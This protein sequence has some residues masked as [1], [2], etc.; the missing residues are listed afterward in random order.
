MIWLK[1]DGPEQWKW[2]VEKMYGEI[3]IQKTKNGPFTCIEKD[4][5]LIDYEI[6]HF[7]L[8]R[9]SISKP[10]DC[11]SFESRTA[12]FGISSILIFFGRLV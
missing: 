2:K 1:M 3:W 6:I 8:W 7:R 4:R 11:K 5:T 12:Q 9:L 10:S